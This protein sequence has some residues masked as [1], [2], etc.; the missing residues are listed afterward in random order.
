MINVFQSDST[1]DITTSQY[2]E[3]PKTHKVP[4]GTFAT[5]RRENV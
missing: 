3:P 5:A 1:I 2:G 4:H